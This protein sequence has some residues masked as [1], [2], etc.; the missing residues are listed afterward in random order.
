MIKNLKKSS[1]NKK[2]FFDLSKIKL[3]PAHKL[4]LF[5]LIFIVCNSV[6]FYHTA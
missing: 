3:I 2:L 5:I 6:N 4:N 1:F